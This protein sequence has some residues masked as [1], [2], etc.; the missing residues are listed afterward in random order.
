MPILSVDCSSLPFINLFSLNLT[1]IPI[2]QDRIQSKN[3]FLFKT[4]Y[5]SHKRSWIGCASDLSPPAT[6][7]TS[8]DCVD[9][10]SNITPKNNFSLTQETR[11]RESSSL[12]AHSNTKKIMWCKHQFT[13]KCSASVKRPYQQP[14]VNGCL[15]WHPISAQVQGVCYS[16]LFR[17]TDYNF[18]HDCNSPLEMDFTKKTT[19]IIHHSNIC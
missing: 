16:P 4:D 15:I 11:W 5:N 6:Q 18:T 7:R 1:Q 10:A 19:L 8:V 9:L 14:R 17:S 13:G 3:C 12:P 2:I